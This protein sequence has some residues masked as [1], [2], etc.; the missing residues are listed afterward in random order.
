MCP[1]GSHSLIVSVLRRTELGLRS[2]P[3]L[4]VKHAFALDGIQETFELSAWARWRSRSSRPQVSP[5]KTHLGFYASRRCFM[6]LT[7][8][9]IS[10]VTRSTRT[11]RFAIAHGTRKG[12]SW[13]EMIGISPTSIPPVPFYSW[14]FATLRLVATMLWNIKLA[15][16]LRCYGVN[17]RKQVGLRIH[18]AV[19]GWSACRRNYGYRSILAT[20]LPSC[21]YI[22]WAFTNMRTVNQA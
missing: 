4:K 9:A 19:G 21:N 7:F 11:T 15:T 22:V 12:A 8:C 16:L 14:S 5:K 10:S 18:T 13:T 17:P 3:R 1:A 6:C 20:R 2:T